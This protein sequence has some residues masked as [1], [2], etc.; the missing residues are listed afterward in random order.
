MYIYLSVCSSPY[1]YICFQNKL[2]FIK[3][4]KILKVLHK[5]KNTNVNSRIFI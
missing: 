3:F 5:I 1:T 2:Q 4:A